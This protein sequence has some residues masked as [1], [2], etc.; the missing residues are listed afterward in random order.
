MH[1]PPQM[2]DDGAL[3]GEHVLSKLLQ[4]CHQGIPLHKWFAELLSWVAVFGDG[5]EG[6]V[7]TRKHDWHALVPAVIQLRNLEF[8][9]ETAILASSFQLESDGLHVYLQEL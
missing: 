4:S 5:H 7:A 6:F 1:M 8:S 9:A 3:F 2:I